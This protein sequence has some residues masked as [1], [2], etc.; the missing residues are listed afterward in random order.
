M[1]CCSNSDLDEIWWVRVI[2]KFFSKMPPEN[3]DLIMEFME[4]AH[5]KRRH[6][7]EE[8][9]RICVDDF[10]AHLEYLVSLEEPDLLKN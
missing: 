10:F 4:R 5:T 8:S 1:S 7:G 6:E 3:Q 2:V 9:F